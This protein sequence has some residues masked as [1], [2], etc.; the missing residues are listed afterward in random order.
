MCVCVWG[1]GGGR[2]VLW[3]NSLRSGIQGQYYIQYHSEGLYACTVE[4][5]PL[6]NRHFEARNPNLF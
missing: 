2:N 4:L 1:G 6:K 3:L 5:K